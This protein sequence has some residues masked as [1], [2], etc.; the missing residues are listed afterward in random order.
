MTEE[1]R[2]EEMA[3]KLIM[4]YIEPIN[5]MLSVTGD[6]IKIESLEHRKMLLNVA[7][8]A[9]REREQKRPI[10]VTHPNG[11]TGTL[12]VGER[13]CVY[14]RDRE[15]LHT[16]FP[17]PSNREELYEMLETMPETMAMLGGRHDK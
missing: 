4:S 14:Y 11:Y 13:M 1:I 15:V 9:L 6:D 2:V 7:I 3:I 5:D 16:S 10:I 12:K 17:S 8:D